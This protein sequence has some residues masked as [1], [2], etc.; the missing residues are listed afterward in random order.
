M[1]LTSFQQKNM[2]SL[3]KFYWTIISYI[4]SK[5]NQFCEYRP[6]PER[7]SNKNKK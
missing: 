5:K 7:P 3:V 6:V 2:V 1:I 4:I